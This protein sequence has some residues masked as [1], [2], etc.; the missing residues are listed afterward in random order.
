[1]WSS[2][3]FLW[4]LQ[5]GHPCQEHNLYLKILFLYYDNDINLFEVSCPIAT[6][7]QKM[8][9][10][11]E[12]KIKAPEINLFFFFFLLKQNIKPIPKQE[13]CRATIKL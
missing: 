9:I 8:H 11:Q 3:K 12:K 7:K 10:F 1:M 6:R 4:K 5:E 2:V 13:K